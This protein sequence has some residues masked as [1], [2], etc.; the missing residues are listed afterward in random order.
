M[1]P[2]PG[3]V[4]ETDQGAQIEHRRLYQQRGDMGQPGQARPVRGDNRQIGRDE[5]RLVERRPL[6]VGVERQEVVAEDPSREAKTGL[7]QRRR[8]RRHLFARAPL[9]ERRQRRRI[10][11][12]HRDSDPGRPCGHA[13]Q[14]RR[15][16]VRPV[17]LQRQRGGGA[18]PRL[19][20]AERADL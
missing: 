8:Q 15:D 13:R 16:V 7:V 6:V 10:G 1:G 2:Q 17:D 12:R 18:V 14:L 20:P 4:V 5:H 19:E 3:E 9:A 11:D